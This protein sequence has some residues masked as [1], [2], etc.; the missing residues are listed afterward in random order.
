MVLK[1]IIFYT[2]GLGVRPNI[3]TSP[4]LL[5]GSPPGLCG[6]TCPYQWRGESEAA[7]EAAR[8]MARPP[9]VILFYLL[10]W[11]TCHVVGTTCKDRGSLSNTFGRMG[12]T[13]PPAVHPGG[14]QL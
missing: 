12:A 9:P 3:L 13:S 11:D 7:G 14:G 4:S 8:L 10:V 2:L 1:I 6:D 5:I